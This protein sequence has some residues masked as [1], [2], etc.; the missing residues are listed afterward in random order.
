MERERNFE[1]NLRRPKRPTIYK[2]ILIC[3]VIGIVLT[4]TVVV[5]VSSGSFTRIFKPQNQQSTS[6]T[7][8][9][10]SGHL[11][12][13]TVQPSNSGP[14]GFTV[15]RDFRTQTVSYLKQL[16]VTWVRYQLRWSIIERTPGQYNWSELDAAVALAN[17]NSI[18]F[19]FPIQ[20]AP[21]WA[22]TQ[23]CDGI[24]FLPGANEITQ[25]ATVLAQ[26]YN[27]KNHHGYIDSYEV[28]NEEYDSKWTGS[29][30]SSIPCRQPSYY[31][32][33]LKA[34]YQAIKAQSPDA[35]VGMFG[36]WWID[37]PHIR[38]FMQWLYQNGYGKYFDFANFHYYICNGNPALT[39]RNRPSLDL[40]WQTFHDVMAQYGDSG[41]PIWLTEIG[42]TI[43][44]V[45]QKAQCSVTPQVQAQYMRFVLNEAVHSLVI[46]HI[47]WYTIDHGNDGMSIT[48]LDGQLPSFQVLRSF[49][50]QKPLWK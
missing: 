33:V 14:Y 17:A 20:D 11:I 31:G 16:G 45:N 2:V 18:H 13:G 38:S 22:L 35:L 39:V 40:E 7:V 19:T 43:D 5:A 28:G 27:G 29:W 4:C 10:P 6:T 26:R 36:L 12:P 25:F 24:H 23:V 1:P 48:Q 15:L 9:G 32:P 41:K 50:Q 34:G 42:W 30:A 46:Q 3:F 37:T 47:F 49:I 44:G 21:S 8:S